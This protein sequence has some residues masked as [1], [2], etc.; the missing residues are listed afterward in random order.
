[1]AKPTKIDQE[2]PPAMKELIREAFGVKPREIPPLAQQVAQVEERAAKAISLAGE[3]LATLVLEE[4]Q[5]YFAKFPDDWHMMVHSWR[6]RFHVLRPT[7]E[8]ET[9]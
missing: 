9:Q 8:G 3:I 1:M 5:H 7:Q 4:N 6:M 2:L